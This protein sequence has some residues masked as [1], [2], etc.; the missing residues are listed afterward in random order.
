MKLSLFLSTFIIFSSG[1]FAKAPMVL[2]EVIYGNDNRME[3]FEAPRAYADLAQST[4]G[5]ISKS[6]FEK[7]IINYKMTNP[8]NYQK[9][10][11][12]CQEERF[13][14]QVV[15]TSCTGFLVAPDILVTAGHCVV[16]QARCERVNWVFGFDVKRNGSVKTSFSPRDVY[17]CKTLIARE[18]DQVSKMDYAVIRLDRKVKGRKPL[19]IRLEGKVSDTAELLVIGHPSGLPTKIVDNGSVRG[20]TEPV[21]FSANLDT[22]SGNSGSPV[23]DAQTGVV[24][25]ILVRGEKDFVPDRERGCSL[26]NVCPE[27]QC[28][29]ED[30]T[31]ITNLSEILLPL[32]K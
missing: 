16:D 32:L 26:T 31:R 25:G 9:R 12:L 4:A 23:I 10:Y 6:V 7:K 5:M 8:V 20:N 15:G 3:V 28:R 27:G 17:S 14:D 11:N 2:N 24:E 19:P 21:Y 29:G 18:K 13:V 1:A 22:F 30:V